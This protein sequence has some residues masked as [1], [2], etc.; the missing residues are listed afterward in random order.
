ML[1]LLFPEQSAGIF[2]WKEEVVLQQ[3]PHLQKWNSWW[4]FRVQASSPPSWTLFYR[5]DKSRLNW[6]HYELGF[7]GEE[8]LVLPAV[9][10]VLQSPEN[11]PC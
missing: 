8:K 1:F 7:S 6:N 11:F 5:R 2:V 9:R 3:H 4:E 10:N